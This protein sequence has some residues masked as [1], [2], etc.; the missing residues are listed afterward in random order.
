MS[1]HLCKAAAV[2][3]LAMALVSAD[4]LAQDDQTGILPESVE[5]M[6]A[7]P[8]PGWHPL[9]KASG[10][11]A[12]AQTSNVPGAPDG[13]TLS[14]GYLINAG[15]GYVSDNKKHEWSN[16][17]NMQLQYTRTPVVD[18]FTKNL[19]SIDLRS[20]YLYHIP[21][22]PWLGPFIALRMTT[23]MLP[24][25]DVRGEDTNILKLDAGEEL[26]FSQ[27][28]ETRPVDSDGALIDPD[29]PRVQNYAA[30]R[31]IALTEAFAPLTL[32]E[33]VGLFAMPLQKEEAKLDMRLGFGAWETFVQDGYVLADNELTA[34]L[35]EI[36]QLQDSVQVGP[37]LS[38]GLTGTVKQIVTYGL[39]AMFMQ[40]VYHNADT[41]LEGVDLMNMEFEAILGIQVMDW[42]TIDYMFKAVKQ[43]LLVDAWQ[44]QNGLLV[45]ISF[46]I[47][48]GE[49]PPP[50]PE[51]PKC[52]EASADPA[53]A[54]SAAAEEAPAAEA[55]P[56]T[57]EPV[58][59][60]EAPA[61]PEAPAEPAP[62]E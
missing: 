35:I 22:V 61:K 37:E 29:H 59:E 24:G 15:L 53:A 41:D 27:Y 14:L 57:P 55:A 32:R 16:T 36:R 19:D 25:Y 48:G 11:F 21:K 31:K 62:A 7:G 43:P 20:A 44:I 12:L 51:C 49:E 34:D 40:P 39:G 2:A 10:N 33:S 58:A 3:A 8:E 23:P 54:E 28:D 60:S 9:L 18:A 56:P 46:N 45:S 1:K 30:G 4:A 6:E 42:L 5:D 26:A 38:V 47:V 50:C 13:V 17:L 52:P